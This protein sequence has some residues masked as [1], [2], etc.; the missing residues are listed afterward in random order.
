MKVLYILPAV[1]GADWA[2]AAVRRLSELG[3]EVSAVLPREQEELSGRLET[4]GI[5]VTVAP[6]FFPK[7]SLTGLRLRAQEAAELVRRER[8]HILHCHSMADV[9]LLRWAHRLGQGPPRVLQ[10]AVPP[11]SESVLLRW[12][13]RRLSDSRDFWAGSSPE[14]CGYFTGRGVP[15]SR[16][17][18][19][20]YGGEFQRPASRRIVL[21]GL[22]DRLGLPPDA[23]LIVLDATDALPREQAVLQECFIRASERVLSRLP[24][25]RTV[26]M[27]RGDEP[28]KTALRLLRLARYLCGDSL[29]F[30]PAV[31]SLGEAYRDADIAVHPALEHN[32]AGAAMWQAAGVLTV[33]GCAAGAGDAQLLADRIVYQLE[34]RRPPSRRTSDREKNQRS[35]PDAQSCAAATL[36]M[37]ERI[38]GG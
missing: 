23:P 28:E 12:A 6:M 24:Q 18:L 27:T 34:N 7:A 33:S 14:L 10:T 1:S 4:L 8:P 25:V 17:F 36:R 15:E 19:C 9:L 26:I 20:P 3:A 29:L 37:Y 38:L 32:G 5:P 21:P 16:V 22:R 13:E 35:Y 2:V 30:A 11:G 31:Q